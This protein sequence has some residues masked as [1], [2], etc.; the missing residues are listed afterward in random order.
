MYIILLS[1]SLLNGVY[2]AAIL[3]NNV[4]STFDAYRTIRTNK[5]CYFNLDVESTPYEIAKRYGYFLEQHVVTS[6][7]GYILTIFR[8]VDTKGKKVGNRQPLVVEH[9]ILLDGISWMVSGNDSLAFY[10]ADA[11]FDVWLI[12]SRGTTLSRKHTNGSISER[13]YWNFSFHE[14]AI[15]DTP[16]IMELISN[17][18]NRFDIIHIGH[19]MGTTSSMIYSILKSDHARKHVKGLIQ[20]AP[21]VTISKLSGG[22]QLVIPF[23]E[24]LRVR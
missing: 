9:G 14:M 19:S 24:L 4:C 5:N 17:H 1:F 20:L 12:N 11:G 18:T 10:F 22:G 6:E 13:D 8:L 7:D 16:Q 23:F 21:V 2:S 15:Y 3:E